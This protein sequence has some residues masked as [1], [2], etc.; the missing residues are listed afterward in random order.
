MAKRAVAVQTPN[1]F[2]EYMLYA[3]HCLMMAKAAPDQQSR[4]IQRE[5]AAEWLK[6]ADQLESY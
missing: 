4:M 2:K 6:L 3:E 5:M 1:K